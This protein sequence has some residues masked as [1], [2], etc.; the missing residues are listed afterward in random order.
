MAEGVS[1]ERKP[2]SKGSAG[3]I[4]LWLISTLKMNNERIQFL[5]DNLQESLDVEVKN[6][7]GGLQD[8]NKK[9]RLAKEIIAL[10]NGGGGYIF[11]GF[12][13]TTDGH[14]E[15]PPGDGER[16][17]FNQ[18]NIA[19]VVSRYLHPPCQ[20][21]VGLFQRS[22]SD[23]QHPVISVPGDH[24][25]PVWARR[26]SP[27]QRTLKQ[28][29]VYV[30]RAGG[31][32]EPPQTQDDWERL[33]DRLVKARQRDQLDAIREIINPSSVVKAPEQPTLEA[34]DQESYE[35]WQRLLQPVP[36]ASPLRLEAGHWTFS[37]S[38]SPFNRPSLADLNRALYLEMPKYSGWP[39]FTYI[40]REPMR[41]HPQ[42]DKIQ[43]WLADDREDVN[44]DP[45][46]SDFWI[47]SR[48][49]F[50]F[51]LRPMQED[52]PR[53]G[54]NRMPAPDR[55]VFD[56]ILPV[57]RTTEFLKFVEALALRFSDDAA[58]FSAILRYHG[59]EGRSLHNS[60]LQYNLLGGGRCA[61]PT[62]ESQI[63]A[64]ISTIAT[65]IEELVLTLLSPIFE[66][67]E[68]SELQQALVNNVVR[69]A[70][71]YR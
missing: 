40:H 67:F 31:G 25:T 55:P 28:K 46:H 48:D 43:A 2:P 50:G 59:T 52:H 70:M 44:A 42:G 58:Q 34:W 54:E 49:G 4:R 7:L 24:R 15:I 53:F 3:I 10:A 39:P 16:E 6:W 66:Q 9:S 69:D 33:I 17:A 47:I 57:Y 23:I 29:T 41:P 45:N 5:I 12:K 32:S 68:F 37:F 1:F 21:E 63:T 61:Q 30:R 22:G 20:C 64:E 56:W 71:S 14:P 13:D 60:N 62:L 19:N 8:E 27:D 18:D 36:A 11:I 65:N 26:D 35:T 51:S 38:I